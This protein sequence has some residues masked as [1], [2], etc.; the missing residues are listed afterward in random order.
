MTE[1]EAHL[2]KLADAVIG[3]LNNE[4]DQY[5]CGLDAKRPFGFSGCWSIA[6]NVCEI[7]GIKPDGTEDG[8]A[9][10]TKDQGEYALGLLGEVPDHIRK[11]WKEF[12]SK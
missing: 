7:A 4:T 12:R 6:R 1:R 8:E 9:V 5:Y 11:R 3:L 10:I 2:D